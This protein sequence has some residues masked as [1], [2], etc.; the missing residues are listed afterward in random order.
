LTTAH[1]SDPGRVRLENEDTCLVDS[2]SGVFAVADGMGGH[3]GGATAS[4]I[5]VETLR[6]FIHSSAR[7]TTITWPYG[8]EAGVPFAANQLKNAVHLANRRI[9]S[10]ADR[11]PALAGMGSTLVAMVVRG[12]RAFFA[13]VGDSR[14]YLWRRGLLKQ[15]SRDDSWAASMLRA[16]ASREAVDS[17]EMRHML[18]RALGADSA[19]DVEV[20]QLPL[21]DGDVLLLCSDGLYGP[22]GDASI[23]RTLAHAAPSLDRTVEALV[24]AANSAGGPDNITAVLVRYESAQGA[25]PGTP[26]TGRA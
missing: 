3:R 26:D 2:D 7:D 21:E 17:H 6:D 16:G 25:S 18:T 9:L 15:V 24:E 13:G 5:A 14:L 1:R 12:G 19:L 22:I 10:E 23:G 8:L 11:V 20:E 4:R